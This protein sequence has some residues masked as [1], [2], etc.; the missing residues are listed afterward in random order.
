M[1]RTE[2]VV[3]RTETDDESLIGEECHIV[4]REN[5]GPRGDPSF[6]KEKRDKYANL[7]LL[8]ATHHKVVDDQVGAYTVAVLHD[9][10]SKHEEWVRSTL[11]GYDPKRQHDDECYADI[12]EDFGNRVLLNE[13]RGWS[14]SVLSHGQPV[15]SKRVDDALRETRDWIL[16]RV[17]P[18]RYPDI[19]SA[20][21]NFRL[22]LQDFQNTFHKHSEEAPEVYYTKKFSVMSG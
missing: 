3:D 1:C 18:G 14:Y 21:T 11:A 10:K 6:P 12:V 5:G 13:W 15:L 9:T 22:V 8:C 7:I 20:F 2:L 4:A 16:S 17:W 19:E